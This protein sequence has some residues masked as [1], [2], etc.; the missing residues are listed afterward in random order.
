MSVRLMAA[1]ML[2]RIKIC[3]AYLYLLIKN[4]LSYIILRIGKED[5]YGKTHYFMAVKGRY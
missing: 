1:D 4:N 2:F 3:I 5:G